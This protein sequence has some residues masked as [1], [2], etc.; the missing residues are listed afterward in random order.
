MEG[1]I[2]VS[3]KEY[4]TYQTH[5]GFTITCEKCQSTDVYVDNTMGWSEGSGSW[6]SIDLT[7]ATCGAFVEIAGG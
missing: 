1:E 3:S 5:P 2:P 4:A 6:G 7:C